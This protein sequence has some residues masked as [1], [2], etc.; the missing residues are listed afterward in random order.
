L[1]ENQ[2]FLRVLTENAN[3]LIRVFDVDGRAVY[4]SPSVERHYGRQPVSVFDLPHPD[5]SERFQ[6]WW[7]RV[8]MGSMERLQWRAH[9]RKG[10]WRWLESSAS[11]F[12]FKGKT[13][14]LTVCRDITERKRTEEELRETKSRLEVILDASPL[15]IT[16][17]D[18]AGRITSWNKAAERVF[19]WT[20]AELLGQVCKTVLPEGVQYYLDS[21]QRVLAGE[22]ILAMVDYRRKKDGVLLTCSVS[23]APQR[24]ENGQ[25]VGVTAIIEDI[26]EQ[27]KSE[28]KLRQTQAELAHVA[29]VS[30]MGELTA[31]IAH[32]INQPLAAVVTNSDAASRWLAAEPPNLQEARE[33]VQRIARDATRASEV[34]RRIRALIKKGELTRTP[35]D[36]NELIHEALALVSPE[37]ARKKVSVQTDLAQ[38]LSHPFVDRVQLQQVL[39]N[40]FVNAADSM[41][42]VTDGPRVLRV[43]TEQ[44]DGTVQVAVEDN[45]RGINAQEIE[46]LFEPF[47]TTKPQGLGMGLVISRSIVEAHEGHLW[48][49]QNNGPG[50]T[51]HFSLPALHGGT[52]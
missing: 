47:Y 10:E 45:G 18:S 24:N 6:E 52:P 35:V 3:D 4:L 32:E 19:G 21:I 17:L 37:L 5:D 26:T 38:A 51:F 15:P 40:L 33:A 14:V 43:R 12:D 49:R 22:T 7:Q 2:E 39:L 30:I 34:I 50:A 28:E 11:L 8:L 1:K 9:D 44:A 48:A 23:F 29:R 27:K 25:P 31:S 41:S 20:E 16:G 42:T 46:Q 13:H 36:L